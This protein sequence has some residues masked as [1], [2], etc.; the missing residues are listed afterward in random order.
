MAATL[1]S[2]TPFYT[3]VPIPSA[4]AL[5]KRYI[6]YL[7][8]IAFSLSLIVISTTT[9]YPWAEFD[10]TREIGPVEYTLQGSCDPVGFEYKLKTRPAEGGGIIGGGLGGNVNVDPGR[11]TYTQISGEFLDNL[12]LIYDSYRDKEFVYELKMQDPPEGSGIPWDPMMD[13]SAYLNVTLHSDRVP[14]WWTS[15]DNGMEVTIRFAGCDLYPML[16]PANDTDFSITI[17]SIEVIGWTGTDENGNYVGDEVVLY[18]LFKSLTLKSLNESVT[19]SFDSRYPGGADVLG[20]KAR[21]EAHLTDFWGRPEKQTLSG[22]SGYMNVYPVHTSTLVKGAGVP[23]SLIVIIIS[24]IT[25]AMSLLLLARGR[26]THRIF[27]LLSALSGIVAVTWFYVGMG[28]AVDLLG[29]RL[30]GAAQGLT[31]GPGIYICLAGSIIILAVWFVG[32]VLEFI[33]R[34]EKDGPSGRFKIVG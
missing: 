24:L 29:Q 10:R 33:L 14:F 32:M 3:K 25:G 6:A 18:S 21:I 17:D 4:V 13:P 19:I 7:V 2:P 11:R 20:I 30:E 8:L 12:G 22:S 15:G 23:F 27:V 5:A 1:C 9:L 31:F 34:R 16:D 28:S 26:S